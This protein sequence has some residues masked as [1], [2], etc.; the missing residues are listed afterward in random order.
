MMQRDRGPE[1]SVTTLA[2]E[3]RR[4]QLRGQWLLPSP[5]LAAAAEERW[6]GY[7]LRCIMAGHGRI[8]SRDVW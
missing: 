6:P 1:A 3:A 4:R 7:C 5:R 2:V 8:G